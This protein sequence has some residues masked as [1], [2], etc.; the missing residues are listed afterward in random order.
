[1][2]KGTIIAFANQKGGVGK[3][4]T[5]VNLAAALSAIYKR[6]LLI[7]FDP[8]GNASTGLG[9][10]PL[11][12]KTTAYDVL[13]A[14]RRIY[15]GIQETDIPHVFLL[16]STPDLSAAEV[17]LVST[18]GREKLLEKAI[19]Q[20]QSQFDY[21]FIDCPPSL[22]LLTLNALVAADKVLIPLQC[23]FYALEGL[24]QLIQNIGR[25]Q[26]G[27]NKD[28]TLQ[29]I[30]LT[31]YD[32]RNRLN[33]QVAEDAI[34]HLGEKVYTTKIPRNI[35]VSEAP[36]HGKPVLFYDFKCPGSQAYVKLA[37]EFIQREEPS[38]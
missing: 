16:P 29:G 33:K 23:E 5:A 8:Q 10:E 19:V 37:Q 24:S 1:M 34:H 27:L 4:T 12:R 17:E 21:I 35:R 2:S 7:D 13:F 25:V 26:K 18:P 30:V 15:E 20:I 11:K 38:K 3:T 32:Q 28:L 6:V 14:P 31:M 36:S 22:G 9:F